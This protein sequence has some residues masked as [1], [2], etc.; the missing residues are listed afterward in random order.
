MSC[1][2]LSVALTIP[3]VVAI[4]PEPPAQAQATPTA[5]TA[6]LSNAYCAAAV[7][8]IGGLS[9]W[10]VT[11]GGITN[12]YP[13]EEGEI[14]EDPEGESEEWS[15]RIWANSPSEAQRK[16]RE[17]AHQNGAIYVRYRRYGQGN[18]YECVVRTLRG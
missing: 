16:C 1:R 2:L 7:V 13:Y 18:A 17:Y 11:Q 9:Y 5:V 4:L 15:D 6:C 12:Y 10:A 14:L 3:F 8:V